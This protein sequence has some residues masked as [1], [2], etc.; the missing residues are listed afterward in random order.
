[1][2]GRHGD[3]WKVR[4]MAAPE[5]GRANVAV[6]AL[7]ATTLGLRRSDVRIVKGASSRDKTV[8][9]VGLT[10]VEAESLLTNA[11]EEGS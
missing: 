8:E 5:R 4:V 2:I 3:A 10:L 6:V 9:L 1:M 11:Q 7:L